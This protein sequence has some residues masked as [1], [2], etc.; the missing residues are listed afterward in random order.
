MTSLEEAFP[1]WNEK[2]NSEIRTLHCPKECP[3]CSERC[4]RMCNCTLHCYGCKNEHWWYYD[5]KTKSVK[6]GHS[7]DDDEPII[8]VCPQ[9]SE[10]PVILCDCEYNC[11]ECSNG[12][13]WYFDPDYKIIRNEDPHSEEEW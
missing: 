4:S 7:D 2:S 13:I 3:E 5:L 12:H 1:D 9:C 10:K 8:D 6:L 11:S